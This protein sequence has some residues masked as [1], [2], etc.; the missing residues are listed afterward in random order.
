MSAFFM[1]NPSTQSNAHGA[2]GADAGF[3]LSLL[4]KKCQHFRGKNSIHALAA[5]G[6]GTRGSSFLHGAGVW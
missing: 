4:R 6:R 1:T 2:V 3:A 5:L